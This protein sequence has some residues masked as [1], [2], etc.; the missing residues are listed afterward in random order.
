MTELTD[1]TDNSTD[2]Q[3]LSLRHVSLAVRRTD[4]VEQL[5]GFRKHHRVPLEVNSHTQAFIGR[6][7]IQNRTFEA[8]GLDAVTFGVQESR[9]IGEEELASLFDAQQADESG[10]YWYGVFD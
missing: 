4:P 3:P 7:A 2:G 8:D 9:A 5:A 10:R 6:L 1:L